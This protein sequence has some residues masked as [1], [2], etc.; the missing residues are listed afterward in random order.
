MQPPAPSQLG[1]LVPVRHGSRLPS[2]HLAAGAGRDG[3]PEPGTWV[4]PA[5]PLILP[6]QP[7]EGWGSGRGC[8]EGSGGAE[9]RGL[10]LTAF[11]WQRGS[12]EGSQG[13]SPPC[14]PRPPPWHPRRSWGFGCCGGSYLHQAPSSGSSS[15]CACPRAVPVGPLAVPLPQP[16]TR[17]CP[18]CQRWR[19]QNWSCAST[20]TPP[21][22]PPRAASAPAFV[23]LGP[24]WGFTAPGALGGG[25]ASPCPLPPPPFPRSSD[26]LMGTSIST[27]APYPSFAAPLTQPGPFPGWG[28]VPAG[29]QLAPGCPRQF[30]HT[31]LELGVPGARRVPPWGCGWCLGA[32]PAPRGMGSCGKG[33]TA[34][35]PAPCPSRAAPRTPLLPTAASPRPAPGP[36]LPICSAANIVR[37]LRQLPRRVLPPGIYRQRG[38]LATSPPLLCQQGV[39]GTPV[40]PGVPPAAPKGSKLPPCPPGLGSGAAAGPPS[41]P[42]QP[43]DPGWH[44]LPQHGGIPRCHTTSQGTPAWGAAGTL[45]RAPPSAAGWLPSMQIATGTLGGRGAACLAGGSWGTLGPHDTSRWLLL[46]GAA[47]HPPR[48]PSTSLPSPS[49]AAPCTLGWVTPVT[50]CSGAAAPAPLGAARSPRPA[51]P[52]ATRCT[53]RPARRGPQGHGRSPGP[54]GGGGGGA[55]LQRK[56]KAG[57]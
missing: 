41:L 29:C 30:W 48:G 54:R 17:R 24:R 20:R 32:T 23:S 42:P 26:A 22:P 3:G 1:V 8:G 51:E 36:A 33:G 56:T 34:L 15:P 47:P 37:G 12:S 46:R 49:I 50:P 7:R 57:I 13:Q 14:R 38:A 5:M 44:P 45:C 11:V 19:D 53:S 31:G 6:G 27:C 35:S 21:W 25:E 10:R 9:P 2:G 43:G 52:G 4:A 18:W 55:V 39:P 16:C 28:W 40:L